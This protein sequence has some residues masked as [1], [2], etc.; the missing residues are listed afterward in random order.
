MYVYMLE[1]SLPV[2]QP[3]LFAFVRQ[4]VQETRGLYSEDKAYGTIFINDLQILCH[5]KIAGHESQRSF[6]LETFQL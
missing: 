6:N 2:L 5:E 3:E 4:K 1:R